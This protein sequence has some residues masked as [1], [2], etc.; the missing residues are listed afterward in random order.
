[1]K[2][3][4]SLIAFVSVCNISKSQT[5][6]K[7]QVDGEIY[8][9]FAP[10]A[11]KSVSK[12]N[13]NNIQ[14]TKLT[15]VSNVLFKYGA[16]KAYKPFYQ[17]D[18][19]AKLPYILKVEFSQIN[20]VEDLIRELKM[21][22]GVEYAEKV[23][24]NKTCV[25]PNDPTFGV[26]LT[27][28]NAQN[29]WAISTGSA[30]ITVAVVDNAEDRSHPDLAANIWTN[31]G[32]IAG[33]LIDDDGNGY[34]DDVNGY[35]VADNDNNTI[36]SNNAMSHGTHVSGI[37]A[38]VTNNSTGMASI[39][40]N[41]KL[42]PVKA[43]NNTGSTTGISA[44]YQG[45]VYAAK[46][47]AR[48]ISCSWGGVSTAAAAEQSVID[49]AWGKG[50]IIFCA[51]GNDGGTANE[52]VLHYPAAYN[53]VYCVASV[54]TNNV[55]SSFS[56]RGP[57]VDICAPGENI[58]STY[59]ANTYNS[60]SGTSMATPLVAG[61]AGLM[62]SKTP[63]MTQTDV[64]NCISSSAANV[65]SIAAN[66]AY[67]PSLQLGAGRIEAFQAMNCAASFSSTPVISNFFTLLQ[68][69]CPSTPISFYDSSLYIPTAWSWTF[70]AGIPATSTSSNPSVQ[71]AA[72][73]TYS[74][75]LQATNV[76]GGNTKT[77]LAYITVAGPIALPLV[78]GFQ[79]AA[80]VPVNWSQYNIGNDN[81]LW[82]KGVGYGGFG[83]S[84]LSA[85]FDNYNLDAAGDRDEIRTPKYIFSSIAS[86]TLGFDVAY[87]EFDNQYS[88]TLEV[89]LSTNC[90]ASWTSI[91]SKGGSVLSTSAGTLQANTFTPT[92]AAW[93]TETVNISA[94][95]SGQSNVMIS[96]VNHGHY[97]QA[98]Y[99]DNVNI[100]TTAI[101]SPTANFS[102]QN[103]VC[104]GAV[105]TLT[106]N[107]I[108]AT[109]YNWSM[110]GGTPA[111][112]T[113]TNP[114]VSYAVAGN[115][116]ITLTAINGTLTSVLTKTLTVTA[117]P[118]VAVN[119]PTICSGNSVILTASGA[120]TYSWNT[121]ATTNTILVSPLTT[122][123]YTV[124]GT[125]GT[126]INTKTTTVT[127][128]AT[129]TVAVSNQ[130][131]CA[132]GT[133]TITA[134]GATTY[135]WNT[136]STSNPLIVSPA[137]TTNYTVTGTNL[138]CTNTKTVS[139]TIGTALTILISPSNPSICAGGSTTITASGATTYTWSTG[140]NATSVVFTPSATSGYAIAG[141]IGT[142]S[143]STTFSVIVNANPVATT[144][145]TTN[146][147]CFG[148]SNGSAFTNAS[149]GTP[150]YTY[151]W[152]PS[153]QTTS[154]LNGVSAGNYTCTVIDSKGC[155]ANTTA[156]I[157][158]PSALAISSSSTIN[159]SCGVCNGSSIYNIS[160]G[161]PAYTYSWS[162]G[163][164]TNSVV[165]LCAGTYTLVVTDTKLCQLTNTVAVAT[166]SSLTATAS[167]TNAS[168]GS[169]NDGVAIVIVG[170][171][172]GPYTYTWT[173]SGGNAATALGLA[174]ACYTVSINDASG[175][176][177]NTTTCVSF[178]TGISNTLYTTNDLLIYPNP[179]KTNVTVQFLGAQ[180]N[181]TIYNN[182]G[183]LIDSKEHNLS[184]ANINL[185]NYAKG[186]Y[187]IVIEIGK[188][189]LHK[190]LIVE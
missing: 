142:C 131:I 134:S 50:C 5:V 177:V 86:A 84:T 71:W 46:V 65:Y 120:T 13:P 146:V 82:T 26:H 111:T 10:A 47:K 126:C 169:C 56:C 37:A 64:L 145:S 173:P 44:G 162:N 58:Y 96:F 51:A 159:T 35:D 29:A 167:A 94:L 183:Q 136:G 4:L 55:K 160:G 122:T 18:D 22:P 61:M 110:V 148:G 187:L 105:T 25:T 30:N 181:Y 168:C 150:A 97:G 60:I 172:T 127:V 89:K 112:S 158:Q 45:I 123:N 164:T 180:F 117:T 101:T 33:N 41:I 132:G 32:E 174:P 176:A 113:A 66:S 106:N 157:T 161:T 152:S 149:S 140:S 144:F 124:T 147:S 6:Y 77:K 17:A 28:I 92:P 34:V 95:T 24:L 88:D 75:A 116:S 130:T 19:D 98:L 38:G 90:G 189:T 153:G 85:L 178:A 52:T 156:N 133:A 190:K 129:P 93:R 14:I 3:I 109:S 103:P 69:T 8:V 72:P 27:Q 36:P 11:L 107:S 115:Y 62:L 102:V 119:S 67:T 151:S 54:A 63:F 99:L 179:A 175:C 7:H 186:V 114:A 87:K 137:V 15:N 9:K 91:Y 16:T 76:N 143:G 104:S 121:S 59:P 40:W 21:I 74:V 165:G 81:V 57:W 43:Q 139:V 79:G 49:Y 185:N 141:S 155:K 138:G 68:N 53:N 78:E 80:F 125:N 20:Q 118:T 1:M 188:Q 154:T 170:G 135:S 39:S 31:P 23:S 128:N 12:D 48:I 2:K 100:A 108:G 83:T 184:V 182:L 73:G 42:I 171:G 163:A 166:S 70:Q